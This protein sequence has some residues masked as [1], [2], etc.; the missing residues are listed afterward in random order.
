MGT[1]K[2]EEL[3]ENQKLHIEVMFK[4]A[5]LEYDVEV[6]FAEYGAVFIE[7]IR[8]N[9]Q[10]VNFMK[11]DIMINV[12]YCRETEKPIEWRGCF[13][14]TV[15]YKGKKYQAI[16]C[17]NVGIEVNR[18]GCLRM[19]IGENGVAQLGKYGSVGVAVK[20]VS[21]TGFSFTGR[22]GDGV[23]VGEKIRLTFEDRTRHN[24][25]ELSGKLVRKVELEEDY[26]LYGCQLEAEN[27]MLEEYIAQRQREQARHVQQQLIERTKENMYRNK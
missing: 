21:A 4:N 7:P 22:Q 14:K 10:I 27:K 18:R 8:Y 11:P 13:V 2:L 1:M 25:F 15:E 3:Q 9:N 12:L 5:R 17:K 19:F 20:D 24:R 6:L 16:G 26:I 23:Q